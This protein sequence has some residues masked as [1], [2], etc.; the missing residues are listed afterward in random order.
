MTSPTRDLPTDASSRQVAAGRRLR[1]CHIM[2]A[3]LWAGA[4]VQ[5]AT[6]AS[7]LVERPEVELTAVLF[8][9]GPLAYELRRL[10]VPVTVMDEHRR[11][12]INILASL[13]RWLRNHSVDVVH[14]HRYKDTVLGAVA[15]RLA[16]VR[17]VIRTVHG[18][19]EPMRGWDWAKFKVYEV[20]DRLT[21]RC[22][23]DR[24][25]AVSARMA[26]SLEASGYKAGTVVT[27]HNGVDLRKVRS[28]RS[29]DDVRRELGIG[30]G[31]PLFGTVGRLSSVKGHGHF[32]RAAGLILQ[33][34]R[35]ARFLI[36][37]D[38]PLRSELAAAATRLQIDHACS[39]LGARTDVYDLVAAMDVFILPSL[40]E[41]IPMALLEAMALGRPV[42]ATAV[43]GIPEI[44]THRATGL[45]VNARDERGLADACLELAGA[46]GWARALGGRARRVVEDAFSHEENGRAVVD[47]YRALAVDPAAGENEGLGPRPA[48]TR[49]VRPALRPRSLPLLRVVPPGANGRSSVRERRPGLLARGARK[50]H[51]AAVKVPERWRM[52]RIR[53]EPSELVAALRSA[54]RILIVCHGNIIRS[55]FAARL[56]AQAVGEGG[57]VSVASGG[58]A[59]KPGTPPPPSALL[60]AA[61]LN[62]E[63]G[64][65]LAS[66]LTPEAV[67]T[68]DVI[69]V[70]DIA[71]LVA[72]RRRFPESREK[73]FLLTCL[74]PRSEREVR[75]PVGGDESAFH[76]C[77]EH[78]SECVRPIVG[79]ITERREVS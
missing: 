60:V 4:E 2:S 11:S 47:A 78:I 59:A 65:H 70:M 71:Q 51:Q 64:D 29:R 66:A 50:L 18:Q 27:L 23:A 35:G 58:L 24:I 74:A 19:S 52:D 20:L 14:T 46:P 45:L 79:L 36:V 42:V 5:L 75:D 3:D 33:K 22:F 43:G 77:Y 62:V 6:V 57:R 49:L 15:A 8:N 21:L 76:A 72:M 37:G 25:I 63:L 53:R 44:V 38:G 28:T 68:S 32:L 67:A 34:E 9:E 61:S 55:P 30:P 12:A 40:D 16:G 39:F 73:A 54:K 7:Y 31:T 26:A 10:G 48:Q 17:G 56:L 13:T 1:V 41:G 69:L